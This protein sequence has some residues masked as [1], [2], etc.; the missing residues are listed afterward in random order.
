MDYLSL[1]IEGDSAPAPQELPALI[2]ATPIRSFLILDPH[3]RQQYETLKLQV[4]D[5]EVTRNI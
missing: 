5:L 3:M 1:F 4:L 2:M